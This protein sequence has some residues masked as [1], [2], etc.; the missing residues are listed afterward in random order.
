M[1]LTD[2]QAKLLDD[3]NLRGKLAKF[4]PAPFEVATAVYDHGGVKMALIEVLPH[5]HGCCVFAADGQ[6]PDPK[7]PSG[8]TMKVVFRRGDIFTR[9]GSRSELIESHD[10]D[11]IRKKGQQVPILPSFDMDGASFE[12]AAEDAF[13]RGD[14][15]S[16]VK[17]LDSA[18][19]V[20]RQHI[21]E[22]DSDGLLLLLNHLACLGALVIRLG[23]D[24]WFHQVI[25][26]LEA[27][28]TLPFSGAG[29]FN[30]GA[31]RVWLDVMGRVLALGAFVV[32]RNRADLI[33]SLVL[34]TPAASPF[35]DGMYTNWILHAQVETSKAGFFKSST[36][37]GSGEMSF[38]RGVAV[39]QA[40]LECAN[41]DAPDIDRFQSLLAQF[42]VLAAVTVW[43]H[44]PGDRDFPYWPSY[45]AY[46]P[47]PYE[48]AL[49]RLVTNPEL[50][51]QLFPPGADEL[52]ALLVLLEKQG[53]AHLRRFGGGYPYLDPMVVR[54][55]RDL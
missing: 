32:G 30:G 12:A 28:Y 11:R 2:R 1:G 43:G 55:V 38:L 7:D 53:R 48:P 4:I 27:I 26:R 14:K 25:D 41:T 13:R 47:D 21:S 51:T 8:K 52:R 50:L 34:R 33:P 17:V 40:S 31:P 42:D 22:G 39:E 24:G 19:D 20:G 23:E 54:F 9:H 18:V 36:A 45:A 46:E 49:V 44:A 10:L 37:G 35:T 5:E 15:V 3:A 16:L 29:R 6:Y